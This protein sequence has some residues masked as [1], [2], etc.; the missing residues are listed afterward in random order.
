MISA[1]LGSKNLQKQIKTVCFASPSKSLSLSSSLI[2][3][4]FP[5][6]K[7]KKIYPDL[8]FVCHVIGNTSHLKWTKFVSNVKDKSGKRC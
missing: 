4:D 5:N 7:L 6:K 8:K 3:H 2:V 1:F